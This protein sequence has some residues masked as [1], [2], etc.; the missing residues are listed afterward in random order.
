MPCYKAY[1]IERSIMEIEIDFGNDG[2]K[3]KAI[4]SKDGDEWCVLAGENIQTGIAGFGKAT[5]EAI[6]NFKSEWRNS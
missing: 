6:A 2:F 4:M 1:Y 5:W 3:V